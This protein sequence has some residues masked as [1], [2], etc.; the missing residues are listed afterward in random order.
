MKKQIMRRAWE[1]FRTLTGDRIAKLSQALKMAW[2][3]VK[4]TAK[5]AK[6]M[7]ILTVTVCKEWVEV[8]YE[9]KSGFMRKKYTVAPERVID[10][11]MT[12]KHKTRR[13]GDYVYSNN[14]NC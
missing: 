4:N 13:N 2:A 6:G 8:L 10:F 1:I 7:K 12:R 11:M 5:K 3:E 14:V 9:R